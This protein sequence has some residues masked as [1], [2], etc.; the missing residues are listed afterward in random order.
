[1][2]DERDVP[3]RHRGQHACE[4]ARGS[5]GDFFHRLAGR[6]PADHAVGEGTPVVAEFVTDVAGRAPFVTAVVPLDQE[7]I[8][9]CAQARQ[10]RGPLR[11]LQRRGQHEREVVARDEPARIAGEVLAPRGER[12]VREAGV[13]AFSRPFR[14]AVAKEHQ[15]PRRMVRG[16]MIGQLISGG[17]TATV[18]SRR[19]GA[20]TPR[21]H[22][23]GEGGRDGLRP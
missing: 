11:T 22:T 9:L 3:V 19:G 1:M 21:R 5:C 23:L 14:L 17:H 6:A 10:F 16:G 18:V 7:R 2:R 15:L 20:A 12:D 13:P 4:H 8:D